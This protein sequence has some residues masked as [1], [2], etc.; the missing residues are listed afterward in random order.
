MTMQ[1]VSRSVAPSKSPAVMCSEK[2]CANTAAFSYVWPWGE[3]GAC[4]HSHRLHVQQRAENLGR[5]VPHFVA[6]DPNY[7]PPI[8]RDER[9]Q[10]I[11]A[12]L[13][14]EAETADVKLRNATLYDGHTKLSQECKRLRDLNEQ[15]VAQIADQAA[16]ID[17]LISERDAARADAATAQAEVERLRLLLKPTP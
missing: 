4:C 5:G 7:V 1:T 15:G 17:R 6:V 2:G 13:S 9:T 12:K 3:Q 8:T 11:A 10:L 16:L 14:A